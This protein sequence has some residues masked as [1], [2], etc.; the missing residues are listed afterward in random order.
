[1]PRSYRQSHNTSISI[2]IQQ[3]KVLWSSK[4][5]RPWTWYR[6]DT[7][8]FYCS[9]LGHYGEGNFVIFIYLSSMLTHLQVRSSAKRK[10]LFQQLQTHQG[11]D[12]LLLLLDMVTKWSST[13]VMLRRAYSLQKVWILFQSFMKQITHI[14]IVCRW[15]RLRDHLGGVKPWETSEAGYV[16]AFEGQMGT[17]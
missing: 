3:I 1:M 5:R 7:S 2:Y 14:S 6:G 15:V 11:R 17:C 4:S 16:K 9:H 12:T 10:G 8:R 13:Y